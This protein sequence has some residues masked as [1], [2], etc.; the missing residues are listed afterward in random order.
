MLFLPQEPMSELTSTP[1]FP[2]ELPDKI[3]VL[4]EVMNRHARLFERSSETVAVEVWPRAV[5]VFDYDLQK[6]C[7]HE[8]P[9]SHTCRAEST[10]APHL[11]TAVSGLFHHY[12]RRV[13]MRIFFAGTR[14]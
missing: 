2:D 10:V 11:P 8:R 4:G 12:G 3:M 13:W 14:S 1:L 6:A 9:T 7:A 5:V